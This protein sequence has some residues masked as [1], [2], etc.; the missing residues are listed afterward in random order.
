MADDGS[1]KIEVGLKM[2]DVDRKLEDLPKKIGNRL[3]RHALKVVGKMWVDDVKAKVPVESGELRDSIASKTRIQR[4]GQGVKGTVTVGPSYQRDPND[5]SKS[6][7]ENPGIYGQFVEF[8]L[9]HRKYTQHPFMRP[10][11][12][13][14]AEDV[15]KKFADELKDGLEAAIND[16]SHDHE[17]E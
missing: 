7:T 14:S 9:K 12:D 6:H 10:A 11:F 1:I 2:H 17:H 5:K 15:V 16:T 13:G 4:H 8:G 3:F